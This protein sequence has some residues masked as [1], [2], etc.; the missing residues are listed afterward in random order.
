MKTAARVLGLVLATVVTLIASSG[1]ALADAP[2]GD[3]WPVGEGRSTLD[4]IIVFGGGTAGLFVLIWLFGLLTARRNYV[5][6]AP[7]TA[8]EPVAGNSPDHH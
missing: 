3:A 1:A 4:T 6:P 2:A 7:S 5:P 8:L